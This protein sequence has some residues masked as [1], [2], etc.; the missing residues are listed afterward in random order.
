MF[1][2]ADVFSC[3]IGKGITEILLECWICIFDIAIN[4]GYYHTVHH[5]VQCRPEL[6]KL[7]LLFDQPVMVLPDPHQRL[8]SCLKFVHINRF[9]EEVVSAGFNGSY[10]VLFLFKRCH[11]YHRQEHGLLIIFEY[12]AYFVTVHPRHHYVKKYKVGYGFFY[13]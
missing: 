9:C 6:E 10:P 8:Y 12:P 4:A 1:Y 13:F 11:H 5:A 7:L 3:H 2:R